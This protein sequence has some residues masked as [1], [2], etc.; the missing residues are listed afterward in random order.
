MKHGEV[1][2]RMSQHQRCEGSCSP[3]HALVQSLCSH[4]NVQSLWLPEVQ[5]DCIRAAVCEE[6]PGLSRG[7]E[8]SCPGLVGAVLFGAAPHLL[9]PE[10][11]ELL[12]KLQV[13]RGLFNLWAFK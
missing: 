7:A 1:T 11:A 9:S 3:A 5:S 8:L 4:V 10:G 12:P 6:G 2:W 13:R